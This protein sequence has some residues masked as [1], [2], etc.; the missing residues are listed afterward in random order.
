MTK[1][2]QAMLLAVLG[3]VVLSAA[4]P[5]LARLFRAAVPLVVTVAV[6]AVVVRV[7]WAATRRW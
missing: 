4:T 7:V 1:L 3:L 6:V 2:V 5:T